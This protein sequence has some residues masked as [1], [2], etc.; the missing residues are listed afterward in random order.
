MYSGSYWQLADR[1]TELS[2]LL[3][4]STFYA[5]L[6]PFSLFIGA[7]SLML[8]FFFDRY[9]RKWWDC[10]YV[11][12]LFLLRAGS[13]HIA[14]LIGSLCVPSILSKFSVSFLISSSVPFIVIVC[15]YSLGS[16]VPSFPFPSL[17]L[18][19]FSSI[20]ICPLSSLFLLNR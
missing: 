13:V 16:R 1:Y 8:V 2:K 14:F 17:F 20:C 4:L 3:L 19:Y 7:F 6:S 9:L 10:G 5:L 12:Y 15:C 18:L 11:V